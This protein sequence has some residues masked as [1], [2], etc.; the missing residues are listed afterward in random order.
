MEIRAPRLCRKKTSVIVLGTI[1]SIGAS[2]S[3][4]NARPTMNGVYD[5]FDA[6]PSQMHAI[7]MRVLDSK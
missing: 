3:P 4:R 2:K 6:M 1:D 5:T 7:P